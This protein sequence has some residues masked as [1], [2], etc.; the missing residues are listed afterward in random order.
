MLFA[1]HEF[2]DHKPKRESSGTENADEGTVSFPSFVVNG[3]AFPRR[4]CRTRGLWDVT[5]ARVVKFDVKPDVK[6]RAW[7]RAE[8]PGPRCADAFAY[9]S[10]TAKVRDMNSASSG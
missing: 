9:I 5:L 10:T 6:L 3:N 8:N 1:V 2:T 4:R 7:V